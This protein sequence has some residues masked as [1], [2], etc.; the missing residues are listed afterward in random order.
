[1]YFFSEGLVNYYAGLFC[2]LIFLSGGAHEIATIV[3]CTI[4][5]VIQCLKSVVFIKLKRRVS[6]VEKK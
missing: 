3:I 1:M 2:M 4:Y 6:D 5:E